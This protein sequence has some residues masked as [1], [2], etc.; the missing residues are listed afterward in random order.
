MKTIILTQ[1]GQGMRSNKQQIGQT[2]DVSENS[3][4]VH[5]L[6]LTLGVTEGN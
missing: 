1:S 4:Q 3:N 5:N 6:P 2:P